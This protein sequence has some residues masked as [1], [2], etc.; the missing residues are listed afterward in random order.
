M[1]SADGADALGERLQQSQRALAIGSI[2]AGLVKAMAQQI[3]QIIDLSAR[4]P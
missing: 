4:C 3:L 1:L 2:L